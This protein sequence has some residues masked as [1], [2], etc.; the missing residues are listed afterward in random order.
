MVDSKSISKK[1]AKAQIEILKDYYDIDEEYFTSESADSMKSKL[2]D[3]EKSIR[4][5]RL[6]ISNDGGLK[7]KQNLKVPINGINSLEYS[8]LKGAAKEAMDEAD[9]SHSKVYTLM[10][11]LSNESYS[12]FRKMEGVDVSLVETLGTLFLEV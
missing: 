9:G 7:M 3:I 8:V 1:A 4:K 6:E 10:S 2:F 5:G 12:T 11:F